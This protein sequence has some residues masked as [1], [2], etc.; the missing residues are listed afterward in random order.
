MRGPI[1]TTKSAKE[2]EALGALWANKILA[3]GSGRTATVLALSGDLGAGK[4]TFARGFLRA[5]GVR[6]SAS[7]TFILM[8]RH[9]IRKGGFRHVFHMDAYRLSRV[10]ELA[11]LRFKEVLKDPVNIVL[12]EWAPNIR[13]GLPK[14][15]I[16]IK[17]AH[18]E[19][20]NERRITGS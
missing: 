16:S 1:S 12:V 5:L 9:A 10:S 8:R 4:T 7:P 3:S 6:R 15:S 18:G 20:E 19:R 2:T 11:P 13:K 17:F 14:N